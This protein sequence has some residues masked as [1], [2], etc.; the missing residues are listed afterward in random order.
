[1]DGG[2]LGQQEACGERSPRDLGAG[3]PDDRELLGSG[4]RDRDAGRGEQAFQLGRLR[5]ADQDAPVGPGGQLANETSASRRP[6]PSTTRWS[7]VRAISLIR[8]E[9][10]KTVRPSPAR[11]RR[12]SR[13]HT[14][15]SGVQPVDRLVGTA[16]DLDAVG[17][18]EIVPGDNR[19]S[20]AI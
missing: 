6:R 4:L 7:A 13:I 5:A 11:R 17:Q 8:C 15:P 1:M 14:T 12:R 20:R 10:T 16:V 3:A 9:E 2:E 19:V 18:H